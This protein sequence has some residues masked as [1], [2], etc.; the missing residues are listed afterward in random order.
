MRACVLA[1]VG[2]G[3]VRREGRQRLRVEGGE[4]EIDAI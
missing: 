1:R 2:I 4:K 3:N